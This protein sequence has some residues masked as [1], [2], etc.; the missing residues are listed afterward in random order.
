MELMG[1]SIYVPIRVHTRAVGDSEWTGVMSK[2]NQHSLKPLTKEEVFTFSGICSNDRLDSHLPKMD[3]TTTLRNYA[4]DLKNGVPLQENHDIW[5]N[6]YGRS[7]DGELLISSNENSVRGHWYVMRDLEL[8]GTKTN[9]VIRAIQGGIMKDMSVGFGG[10]E[11][12][13][14]CSSCKRSVFDWDCPHIPG[15]E[16]EHGQMTFSWIV[17]GRLREVS[18]VYTGS[19]PGAYIDK[20][21]EYVQQGQ[22]SKE[23]I[24]RLEQKYQV[25]FDDGKSSIFI[26]KKKEK[27]RK[28]DNFNTNIWDSIE[29]ERK[30]EEEEKW[31]KNIFSDDFNRRT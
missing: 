5:K 7:Y 2:I 18:T 9:D 11:I 13:Y 12:W 28:A 24:S 31:R 8:N 20:A 6:P 19:T 29:K 26:P 25:R 4:E 15:L 16:D 14:R 3:P 1:L 23:N 27:R 22:L 10:N 30:R 17:N 21:R